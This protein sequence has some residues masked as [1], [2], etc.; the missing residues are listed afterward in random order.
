MFVGRVI[1]IS[2]LK[3]FVRVVWPK[4]MEERIAGFLEKVCGVKFSFD[5]GL[6]SRVY[7][8]C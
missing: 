5:D 3:K 8:I 2:F 6:L 1:L 7:R 4:A